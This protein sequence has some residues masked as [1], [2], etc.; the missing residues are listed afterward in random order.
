MQRRRLVM[1][2]AIL[3]LV[4]PPVPA[5]VAANEL[6][7]SDPSSRLHAGEVVVLELSSGS[8]DDHQVMLSMHADPLP[9]DG[10][11]PRVLYSVAVCGSGPFTGLLYLSGSATLRAYDARSPQLEAVEAVAVPAGT[12]AMGPQR[13]GGSGQVFPVEIVSPMPCVSEASL[14]D[15]PDLFSGS[16]FTVSGQLTGPITLC[17]K[18]R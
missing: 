18:L 3:L 7:T 16:A 14:L 10:E 11:P 4:A 1:W 17:V 8:P 15:S 2:G 6:G 5:Y 12:F 13:V 9:A